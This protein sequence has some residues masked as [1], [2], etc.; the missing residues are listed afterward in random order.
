MW[1]SG[2]EETPLVEC[3]ALCS[4][5]DGPALTDLAFL[6][7]HDSSK[8]LSPGLLFSAS[9]TYS[10]HFSSWQTVQSIRYGVLAV[11]DLFR[12]SQIDL[13]VPLVRHV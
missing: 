5:H 4:L 10:S 1:L 12:A 7:S 13:F 8:P 6:L 9:Q 2:V 3:H 11:H